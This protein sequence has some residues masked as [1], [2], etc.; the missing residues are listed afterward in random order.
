MITIS[1][2][3]NPVV[4]DTLS[5]K[6]DGTA[7]LSTLT[8]APLTSS[9]TQITM[10]PPS[11]P[12]LLSPVSVGLISD[13]I[14]LTN[15][16]LGLAVASG[17][18]LTI[19]YEYPLAQRFY[20]VSGGVVSLS[21]PTSPPIA[22]FVKSCSIGFSFPPGVRLVRGSPQ[23]LSNVTP[24]QVGTA[25]MSYSLSVGWALGSGVPIASLLF[26]LV[27]AGLFAARTGMGAEEEEEEESAT[28]RVT[29]MIK[30]FEEKTSLINGLFEE[31]PTA[32]PSELGKTYFDE[33]RVRLDTFRGR[34]LQR[35]N[36]MKQKSTTQKF[37]EL[38]NQI[39]NTEREV[40]RAARD[41]LNLYEQFYTKRMRKEVFD[42][43][44]PNYKKRLEKALN[45]LSDELNIAQRESKLL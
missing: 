17:A 15:S 5:F 1:A 36:D 45:Q 14:D 12:P 39:H 27:L 34:A 38:L 41:M 29:D 32:E 16:A 31:I 43:L 23:T 2:N 8:V 19:S 6:N 25:I 3:G 44:L 33:L 28:E 24:F 9:S 30:A 18:N 37:F 35:L 7:Q 13:G 21:I 10:V 4:R 11:S 42:R 26:V 40:D 20:N 22:A